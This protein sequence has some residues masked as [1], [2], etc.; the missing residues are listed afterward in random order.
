M[1]H[2]SNRAERGRVRAY[3]AMHPN[4]GVR[5]V[6]NRLG[7]SPTTVRTWLQGDKPHAHKS[8]RPPVL[9]EGQLA[10]ARTRMRGKCGVSAKRTAPELHVHRT[11]L[12][13]SLKRH[14]EDDE[15]VYLK[16]R[17]RGLLKA[18]DVIRRLAFANKHTD[19]YMWRD[20]RGREHRVPWDRVVFSDA[21]MFTSQIEFRRGRH[22]PGTWN[23]VGQHEAPE[24]Y[25]AHSAYKVMVYGIITHHGMGPALVPCTGTTGMKSSHYDKRNKRMH[26]GFCGAE[27]AQHVLPKLVQQAR[28]IMEDGS[29]RPWVFMHDADKKHKAGEVYLVEEHVRFMHDWGAK[30]TE[31]NPIENVW[32][33]VEHGKNKRLPECRN[34]DG[35]LKVVGEECVKLN[36]TGVAQRTH[37]SVRKR[38]LA[39]IDAKKDAASA[40]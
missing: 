7:R 40:D 8:G 34:V 28:A 1:A 23:T 4:V 30:L 27:Y 35:L 20:E 17:R 5:K 15:F 36:T 13:R 38:L 6:G 22:A 31:V 26:I 2:Y 37:A 18:A 33:M 32:A 16:Q 9:T 29:A 12:G 10:Y 14:K 19:G 11:T 39:V 24:P 21:S 3:R 25:V